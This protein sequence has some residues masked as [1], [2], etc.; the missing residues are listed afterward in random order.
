M[1]AASAAADEPMAVQPDGKIV[2]AGHTWP[3]AGALARLLPDGSLDPDFGNGGFVVDHRLPGFRALALQPDG[4]IVGAA[5]GGFQLARYLPNGTPDPSFAGGDIGGSDEPDQVHFIY[6]EYG[7][8]AV[9]VRPDGDIVVGGTHRVNGGGATDGLVRAYDASGRLLESIGHVPLPGGSV[10]AATLHDF[11]EESDGSFIGGGSSYTGEPPHEIRP[12]LAR[13]VPGSGTDFDPAFGGGA[14]LVSPPFPSRPGFHKNRLTALAASG[15]KLL[16]AGEAAGTFLLARFNSDGSLDS[17][18]GGDGFI[19]PKIQGPADAAGKR[20]SEEASTWAN[21]LGV[22]A[23]GGLVVGGGTSQWSEWTMSR[24][25]ALHC[26]DCP[27]PILAR[28]DI[29]GHIDPGFGDGG[30][31]HLMKPDGGAFVGEIEQVI[32]LA[33]GKLLVEGRLPSQRTTSTPFVARLNA[34]GS[35]D[36][37]FGEGGL[38]TPTFPCTD[39]PSRLLRRSGCI[40]TQRLR[41]RLRRAGI[42]DRYPALSL[43]VRP[44]LRWAAIHTVTLTLPKSLRL[45][46][47]FRSKLRMSTPGVRSAVKLHVIEPRRGGRSTSLVIHGFDQ[48]PR[49]RLILPFGSLRATGARIQRRRLAFRVGVEFVD[50]RWGTGIEGQTILRRAG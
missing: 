10:S 11:L 14:G 23:D 32:P 43:N 8:A 27:Q 25:I 21:D 22:T 7:P 31:L 50:A 13:F 28:F 20:S 41:L 49:V 12:L 3:E 6:G 46:R 4:D 48:A 39:Q 26:T 33:G 34:D 45:T 36:P 5:V 35:Y 29:G 42:R 1:T 44:S 2:L 37:S 15:G 38:A 47:R 16:A 40:P 18:F 9:S 17:S 19:A 30:L 24:D